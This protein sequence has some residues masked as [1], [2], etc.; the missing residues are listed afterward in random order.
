[1]QNIINVKAIMAVCISTRLLNTKV[2]IQNQT[3]QTNNSLAKIESIEK[4]PWLSSEK[5]QI[6]SCVTAL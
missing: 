3:K 5:E 4:D 1:M 2:L 6:G